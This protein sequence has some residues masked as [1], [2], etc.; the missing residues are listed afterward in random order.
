M[1]TVSLQYSIFCYF[2]FAFFALFLKVQQPL[3]Q[4]FSLTSIQAHGAE[5]LYG[6]GTRVNGHSHKELCCSAL[7]ACAI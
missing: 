4:T 2:S 5:G 1:L 7:D 3:E 6:F